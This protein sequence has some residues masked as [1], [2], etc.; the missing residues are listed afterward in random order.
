[1]RGLLFYSKTTGNHCLDFLLNCFTVF[2]M[3]TSAFVTI[4]L[5]ATVFWSSILAITVFGFGVRPPEKVYRDCEC[6]CCKKHHQ[7]NSFIQ[8]ATVDGS[9]ESEMNEQTMAAM[10]DQ[11]ANLFASR[12]IDSARSLD[13]RITSICC[14]RIS[15]CPSSASTSVGSIA[16]MPSMVRL[17]TS[18]PVFVFSTLTKPFCGWHLKRAARSI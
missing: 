14:F 3:I 1:M 10:I 12:A 4:I 5:W 17:C 13:C 18:Q 11:K 2:W 7:P 6:P 8:N 16:C 15:F 9:D